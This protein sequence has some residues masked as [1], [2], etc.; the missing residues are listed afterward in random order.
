MITL[1]KNVPAHFLLDP[2]FNLPRKKSHKATVNKNVACNILKSEKGFAL[3]FA[4]PGFSKAD[5]SINMDD[6]KLVVKLHK[7][8]S[9]ETKYVSREYDFS[10]FEKK[11]TLPNNVNLD[12][13]AASYDL[14]VLKIELPLKDK[15]TKEID[16]H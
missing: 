5:F 4:A 7:E 9:G 8:I 11:F 1:N 3:E 15:I 10:S 6:G 13:I 14:G 16:I 12:K 2:F